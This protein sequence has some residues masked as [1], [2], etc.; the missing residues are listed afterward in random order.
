MA[1]S[2]TGAVKNCLLASTPVT[3][4]VGQNIWLSQAPEGSSIPLVAIFNGKSS[5]DWCFGGKTIINSEVLIECYAVTAQA[6]EALKSV[7][8]D[9]LDPYV[10]TF[11]VLN[12]ILCCLRET[13]D[14]AI[15]QDRSPNGNPVFKS[16]T[17]YMIKVEVG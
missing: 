9:A 13:E 2:L 5:V 16:S 17:K 7:V 6:S 10:A 1:V 3:A 14:I 4:I 15:E 12:T 11:D 8:T